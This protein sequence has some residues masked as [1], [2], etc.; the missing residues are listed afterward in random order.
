MNVEE[1]SKSYTKKA[2]EK[3]NV[4][5]LNKQDIVSLFLSVSLRF[6]GSRLQD[7]NKLH[8]LIQTSQLHNYNHSIIMQPITQKWDHH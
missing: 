6:S 5:I 8:S 2:I 1:N 4:Y 3:Q 7:Y